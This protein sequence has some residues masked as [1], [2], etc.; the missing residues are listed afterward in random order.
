MQLKDS[1]CRCRLR[2]S[3]ILRKQRDKLAQ[4]AARVRFFALKNSGRREEAMQEHD[5]LMQAFENAM[6]TR[7][8]AYG[9]NT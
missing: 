2:A 7:R 9:A 8:G 5:S 3:P 6:L 4:Q 1:R